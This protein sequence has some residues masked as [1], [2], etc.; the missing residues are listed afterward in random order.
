MTKYLTKSDFLKYQVCPSYFWLWKNKRQLCP[1]ETNS[2]VKERRFEQGNEVESVAR[3]LFP[4]GVT[5]LSKNAEAEQDTKKYIN[6][7]SEIIFQ[8]TVIT[9]NGLL[10]M[11]DILQKNADGW[12]MYEV[13]S[14]NTIDEAKHLSDAAFQKIA[15]ETAGFNIKQ[16]NIIH[17]NGDFIKSGPNLDPNKLLLTENVDTQ[18]GELMPVINDQIGLAL[19]KMHSPAEPTSCPCRLYSRGKHCPTF[20]YFNKDVPDY[21]VYD[22]SRMQGKKLAS[23]VDAEIFNIND[24]PDDFKLTE[25]QKIQVDIE[26]SGQLLIDNASIEQELENLVFPLYFIDYESVNP[27]LPFIDGAWPYQQIVFQYSLHI[28]DTPT[29]ELRHTEYLARGAEKIQLEK[30]V[31]QMRKDIGS[32][33]S[34]IVWNK[35]FECPRNKEMAGL[36][37]EYSEFL[38]DLNERTYDLKD[39]F[40]KNYYVDPK[41]HGSNSIKD[42][43]P[44]LAPQLSYKDLNIGKGDLASVKWF[45]VTLGNNKEEASQVYSDLLKYCK[46]DTLAMVEIYKVLVKL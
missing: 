34:V 28:L 39:I 17:L 10:A 19:D 20:S 4:N 26:K 21:S 43:L 27:A 36:F 15:F 25:N 24:I 30:L 7:G 29:S 40:A 2:E 41:F 42:V 12:N 45:D 13:K 14:S 44:V 18:I 37:P 5:V 46:L 32:V 3:Q 23:L 16:V 11:A 38:L 1:A 22:I 6:T 31:A 35:S 8:A 33:G 9:N